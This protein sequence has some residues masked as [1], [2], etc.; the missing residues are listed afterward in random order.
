LHFLRLQSTFPKMKLFGNWICLWSPLW[1]SGQSSW[2][3]IRRP[4]FDSW[5]YQKKSSGSGMGST[6]PREYNWGATWKKSS[7][8]CL[9][10]RK[11][12]RRVPSRW[13]RGTLYPQKVGKHFADNRRS[14]GRYSSLA[15]S[16]QGVQFFRICL[17][18]LGLA[19]NVL[20]VLLTSLSFGIKY[21]SE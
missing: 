7:G 3:Q 2:L 19:Y 9:E 16:D 4:G 13:P 17:C 14:L 6:Q 10:N 20:S 18:L 15:Y 8:S 12:G 11:Y 21:I 5:N 1:S